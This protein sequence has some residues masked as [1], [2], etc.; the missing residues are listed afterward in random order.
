MTRWVLYL[1]WAGASSFHL[2]I[3]EIMPVRMECR[4]FMRSSI[5]G[6]RRDLRPFSRT[7]L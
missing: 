5:D 3:S 4:I 7:P 2:T 1:F 6:W